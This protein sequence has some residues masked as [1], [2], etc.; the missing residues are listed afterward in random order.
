MRERGAISIG[1]V[2][3]IAGDGFEGIGRGHEADHPLTD[4]AADEY[5]FLIPLLKAIDEIADRD[6]GRDGQRAG[7]ERFEIGSP[8]RGG[9]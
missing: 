8:F 7:G 1:R 6:V 5:E 3:D 9:G 4:R 2:L